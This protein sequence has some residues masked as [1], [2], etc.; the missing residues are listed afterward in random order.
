MIPINL[1]DLILGSPSEHGPCLPRRAVQTPHSVKAH[2]YTMSK[3][4]R[5]PA[6]RAGSYKRH[7]VKGL[8]TRVAAM[9][10]IASI[11]STQSV[12]KR[13]PICSAAALI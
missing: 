1:S 12:R 13:Y 7:L 5:G 4:R 6:W 10:F 3:Q 11:S 8:A 2:R 9:A